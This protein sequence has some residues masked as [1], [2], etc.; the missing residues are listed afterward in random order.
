MSTMTAIHKAKKG[1]KLDCFVSKLV[2][3][4]SEANSIFLCFL[5]INCVNGHD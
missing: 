1:E 2:A 5:I 3:L 4:I